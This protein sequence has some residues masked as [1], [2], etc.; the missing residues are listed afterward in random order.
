MN[1]V[2]ILLYF[3]VWGRHDILRVCL[4][5]VK[6]LVEYKPE[7]FNII[8]YAVC[9]TDEDAA[10][11]KEYG[12]DYAMYSNEYLGAKKNHG[13]SEA[14][15]KYPFDY[16][17]EIGSDDIVAPALLDLY[18][19]Y[20]H[21]GIKIISVDTCYFINTENADVANWVTDYI[22]G[23]GRAI[24]RSVLELMWKTKIKWKISM[25]GPTIVTYPGE[26]AWVTNKTA[27]YYKKLGYCESI[28]QG[29]FSLWDNKK[30]MGLDTDS[31]WNIMKTV[32]A[33]HEQ[34]EINEP[35][36][37]DLKSSENIHKFSMFTPTGQPVED[38]LKPYT[39]NVSTSVLKLLGRYEQPKKPKTRRKK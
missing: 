13:L 9:S 39:Q 15:K 5:G 33:S 24:H 14:L 34:V 26:I 11:L 12:I 18:E 1:K 38:V 23:A 30:Q 10:V 29:E 7:Q 17:L 32:N 35:Y 16:L 37:I 28:T 27:E 4:E 31:L 21:K 3:A 36:V 25:A 8:P 20:F 19:P 22:L 6:A 2:N